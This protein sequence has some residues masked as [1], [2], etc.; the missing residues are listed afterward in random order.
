M[1]S[2]WNLINTCHMCWVWVSSMSQ[3]TTTSRDFSE[4]CFSKKISN[5]MTNMTGSKM[6]KGIT[7]L[8]FIHNNS[9]GK[10]S[11]SCV[12]S[13]FLLLVYFNFRPS[14]CKWEAKYVWEIQIRESSTCDKIRVGFQGIQERRF[15]ANSRR[16]NNWNHPRNIHNQYQ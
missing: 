1:T 6:V 8:F 3:T 7:S 16:R 5:M 15:N 12:W 10:V 11:N 14:E 2:Q 4:H 13:L 9:K